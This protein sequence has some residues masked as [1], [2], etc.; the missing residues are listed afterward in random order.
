MKREYNIGLD[1]GTAS[2]GYAVVDKNT[3]KVIRK[4]G[5]KLLGASLFK[6]GE[7][8]KE[9]RTF[10]SSRK[11]YNRRRQRIKLLQREFKNEIEKVDKDF[12]Q[13]LKESYYHPKDEM[14][15]TIVISKKEQEKI[16][17]YHKNYPTIYHL[18]NE[19]LTCDKKMDIRLLYLAIHHIIKYR[20]NF[21]YTTGDFRIDELNISKKQQEIF[22]DLNQL[23]DKVT[24]DEDAIE[25]FPYQELE[26]ALL[27]S[28][29]TDQSKIV[30][31]LFQ[32]IL[33]KEIAKEMSNLLT[34]KKASIKKLFQLDLEEDM[35][36]QLEGDSYEQLHDAIESA[37]GDLIEVLEE[38]KE[39]YNMIFLKKM[40]KDDHITSLSALMVKKYEKHKED[41]KFLKNILQNHSKEYAEMFKNQE[42]KLC[43]YEQ[44][45]KNKITKEEFRNKTISLIEKIVSKEKKD[46]I[47]NDYM[48]KIKPQLEQEEFLPRITDTDNGKYPYQLNKEELRIIIEKQSKYY[49]FLLETTPSGENKL[50]KLLEFRIPYYVGPLNDTTDKKDVKK[51]N[52]WMIRKIDKKVIT[53]Y[54]F[55]EV[56]DKEKTAEEFITRMIGKCTYL[57]DI[58]AIAANSILYSKFKVWNELKQIKICENSLSIEMQ[59][60]IYKELFLTTKGTITEKKFENYLKKTGEYKMYDQLT[61][62]GYSADRRFANNMNSYID[63]FGEGGFFENTEYREEDA[64]KII[65]W[66][67]IF[68]DK[69]ILQR[70]LEKE[71]SKLTEKTIKKILN[72]RY[73]GWGNLSRELLTNIYYEDQYDG[74]KRN[75]MDLLMETNENFMQ[76]ISNK[77][78]G[79]QEQI[80][81]YNS[82][83]HPSKMNYELVKSLVTSP[84][85]KKGIYIALKVVE[86]LIDYMGEEPNSIIIEMARG[87]EKKQRKDTRKDYL[88]KLYQNNKNLISDYKKLMKELNEQDNI[89]QK[90]FLYFIQEGKC[91]Y[92]GKPLEIT[93][94]INYEIDHI[95]PRSLYKNDSIDNKALVLREANQ[96]KAANLVLPAEYRNRNNTAWWKRLT[97]IGLMSPQKF[98][99]LTRDKYSDK[100]IEGFIN[101]QLVETRQITKHVVNIIK[102]YHKDTN[103]ICIPANLSSHYREKFKLYKFRELNDHHHAK[104]AYLA[105]VLGEYKETYLKKSTDFEKL[106]EQTKKW[107]D[108]KKYKELKYGY[109]INS[110]DN[111]VG[112]FNQETGEIVFD[113]DEFNKTIAKE[114]YSNQ[115]LVSRKTEIQT[116]KFYDETKYKKQS[117]KAKGIP[118]KTNLKVELYGYYQKP[119]ASYA[120]VVKYEQK[121]KTK[122]Q[123]VGIPIYID[124]ISKPNDQKRIDYIKE[125]LKLPK[126][127]N[128]EIVKDKIPFGITLNIDGEICCLVGASDK[129][130]VCNAKEFYIDKENMKKWNQ[131]FH[132]LFHDA[133]DAVDNVTYEK[134]LNEIIEYI[135]RKIETEFLLYR[136]SVDT[137]KEICKI[138]N[139]EKVSIE[140]KEIIIKELLRLLRYNSETANFKLLDKKWNERFGRKS[141]KTITHATIIN[142]SI[143]GIWE[144]KDEF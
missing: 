37:I 64:E 22:E 31:V 106:R 87:E 84:A 139:I 17:G 32:N 46:A 60:K 10:R 113:A 142:R 52:A 24:I 108:T 127:V 12:Y 121:G 122:Q 63:F 125:L 40:F 94:L 62:K 27:L 51:P 6:P 78:Y 57:L 102:N 26:K 137:I 3:H 118:I 96:R 97:E 9:R 126:E 124:K 14:N 42:K 38:L 92:T 4:G 111:E 75:I 58:P 85:T 49:P 68:E 115:V 83:H 140:N 107:I 123:M 141:G 104:D 89:D 59:Q 131:T 28:S 39:L 114:M 133:K 30:P 80:D 67:T 100:D 69:E 1:I 128:L 5:K 21:L 25:T 56:I 50:I 129:I 130:E 110:I 86:E 93:Q 20:G 13:K 135:I 7:S 117:D 71:Y 99:K 136:S 101:R 18:R 138:N 11:R 90:L 116:G 109:V 81:Q 88:K 105:A 43:L 35:K 119:Q 112:Q 48:T 132:R 76:I 77:K 41:L 134:H 45:V 54:N 103:V 144:Q 53:P 73:K 91:L 82:K 19:L 66:I 95:L 143:T 34:G 44:Y 72:C 15:K 36:V 47:Y 65:D 98:S 8:A 74:I 61:I 29:K 55:D 2:V 70:K 79:F 120:V 33:P 16:K 23:S